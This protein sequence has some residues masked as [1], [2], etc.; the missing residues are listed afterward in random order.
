MKHDAFYEFEQQGWRRA[1]SAYHAGFGR[2]TSQAVFPLLD[3]AHVAAGTRLLDVASGPGYLSAAAAARGARVTGIDFSDAM[4]AL[5]RGTYPG[6]RFERGSAEA[7]PYRDGAFDAVTMSF[8]LGHLGDP[9]RALREARRVL[10]PG[11]RIAVSWWMPPDRA[12]AF[13][14]VMTAIEAHGTLEAGLPA[15]PPFGALG[16]PGAC[17]AALAAAGFGAIETREVAMTWR[18]GSAG[19]VFETYLNGSVRTAG[20]LRAQTAGALAAIRSA[21]TSGAEAFA[22]DGHGIAIPMPCLVCAGS[23]TP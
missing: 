3:A 19:E 5:A 10:R 9:A 23:N 15:G 4:V 14:L 12:Q 21:V 13:A 6:V 17:A 22:D 8:V 1:A 7:L 2:L 18:L 11:G 16:E 20:L